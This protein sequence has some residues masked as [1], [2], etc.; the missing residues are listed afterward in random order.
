MCVPMCVGKFAY[1]IGHSFI[2]NLHRNQN[3]STLL[4][5]ST[6]K[7]LLSNQMVNSFYSFFPQN[8]SRIYYEQKHFRAN[9]MHVN[10]K[11]C[12]EFE[13]GEL[14]FLEYFRKI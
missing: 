5:V 10:I 6:L 3:L 14:R 4:I 8:K 2:R 9:R 12:S 11:R 1:Q 7:Y 13:I